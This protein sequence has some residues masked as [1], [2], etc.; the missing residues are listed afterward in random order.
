MAGIN[1]VA[2]ATVLEVTAQA[3]QNHPNA[4]RIDES[5]SLRKFHR[6]NMHTFKV[7][8]DPDGLR[9]LRGFSDDGLF[10]NIKGTIW[11]AY[12]GWRI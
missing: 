1:V 11:Y 4:G 10:F 7:K 12:A 3:M 5:H 9:G 6:E 8:Y 2:I